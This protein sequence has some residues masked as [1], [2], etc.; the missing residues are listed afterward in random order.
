M[1]R[2]WDKVKKS[3]EPGGCWNWMAGCIDGYGSFYLNGR[4]VRAHRVA[5][6]LVNGSVPHGMCV[7]HFC[8]NRA[9]INPEHLFLGKKSRP[10]TDEERF[11]KKVKKAENGCWEWQASCD[12]KGYG[13]IRFNGTMIKAHR[14]M[15]EIVKG[16]IPEGLCV[17]HRCDNPPCVNPDHLFLGTM[18]D[19][20]QD[21]VK[22]GRCAWN[23]V[24][25]TANQIIEIRK[26]YTTGSVLYRE[27]AEKH[28]VAVST[29]GSIIRK[30]TWKKIDEERSCKK[31]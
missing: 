31:V 18:K 10:Y 4:Q 21:M 5:W 7:F 26:Q 15:W 12:K 29:I 8:S 22:K 23:S 9:C 11:W 19:N 1:K 20:S 25:L 14:K 27:L 16:P 24:K 13:Q 2:F 30:E 6:E 3:D 17:L 28:G